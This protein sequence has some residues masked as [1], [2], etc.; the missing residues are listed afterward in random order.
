MPPEPL[1]E[2]MEKEKR[3][4]GDYEVLTSIR[5][6]EYEIALLQNEKAPRDEVYMC[7]FIESNSMFECC[8]ECMVSDSYTDV[9]TLYGERVSEKAEEI[10]KQ[11]EQEAKLVGNDTVLTKN[12]CV[13]I[14]ENSFLSGKVIVLK[15]EVLRPEY[16]R[17]S[18]QLML[19]MGGFGSYPNAR[20]RTCFCV[21]L[22]DGRDTSWWRQDVL[23]VLPED[24]VPA[25]AKDVYEQNRA[26]IMDKQIEKEVREEAR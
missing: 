14:D 23:G 20:G 25:W 7:A 18:H 22:L 4:I 6:G 24:K 13:P 26:K 3:K 8:T 16:R 12:D 1:E 9:A 10:Q 19:C 21:N 15:P 5:I 17:Q 11:I 2:E